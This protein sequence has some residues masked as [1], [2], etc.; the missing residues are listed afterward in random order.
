MNLKSDASLRGVTLLENGQSLIS[1]DFLCPRRQ[2]REHFKDDSGCHIISYCV[3][4]TD[5]REAVN[6]RSDTGYDPYT[7]KAK[8]FVIKVKKP[9][10]KDYESAVERADKEIDR[11]T[12]FK[13]KKN[14]ITNLKKYDTIYLCTPLW[15][16][17]LTQPVR[18]LQIR[19]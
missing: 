14:K 19:R 12:Q 9:Y 3:F 7:E 17:T 2:Y 16:G 15:H 10:S 1:D 8:S 4:G 5:R 13:L 11:N 6:L 18:M